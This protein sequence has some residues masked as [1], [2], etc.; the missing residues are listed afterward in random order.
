MGE[1]VVDTHENETPER[2]SQRSALPDEFN[3]NPT[4]E[5][6]TMKEKRLNRVF[7]G[8]AD[9]QKIDANTAIVV[10]A[11]CGHKN[12]WTSETHPQSDDGVVKFNVVEGDCDHTDELDRFDCA[13][14]MRVPL[15]ILWGPARAT[16]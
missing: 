11:K 3:T 9:V 15:D 4:H 7:D 8:V 14:Y 16:S 6:D 5:D 1:F 2:A 12:T 10:C 13:T